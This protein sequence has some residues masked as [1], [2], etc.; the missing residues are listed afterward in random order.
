MFEN[1]V[2]RRMFGPR[3]YEVT[4]E[5][6]RLYNEELNSLYSS[7]NI[8]RMIKSRRLRWAGH[9]ARMGERRVV[10]RVLV[11]KPERKRPLKRPRRR[12]EDNIKKDLQEIGCGGMEW[13]EL[14]LDRDR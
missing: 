9:A 3:R 12:W 7:S 11:G 10:Y 1:S 5:W 13:I 4:R 2:L 6:R 14:A 8:V